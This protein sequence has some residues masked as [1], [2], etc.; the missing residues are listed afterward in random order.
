MVAKHCI[1]W[2]IC[3]YV[4]WYSGMIT[5]KF[6][7]FLVRSGF[8][9]LSFGWVSFWPDR[10]K[11]QVYGLF[12]EDI[13]DRSLIPDFGWSNAVVIEHKTEIL[14]R[15]CFDNSESLPSVTC[16]SNSKL[17]RIVESA[18]GWMSIHFLSGHLL[19]AGW[20]RSSLVRWLITFIFCEVV[21]HVH[22]L[23]RRSYWSLVC[24]RTGWFCLTKTDRMISS[25]GKSLNDGLDQMAMGRRTKA[26]G[27]GNWFLGGIVNSCHIRVKSKR[28][29][30][31]QSVHWIIYRQSWRH[32]IHTWS[33]SIK[34]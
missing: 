12:I 6:D 29:H 20:S 23:W 13:A 5:S 16:E 3:I 31:A 34:V 2:R 10:G 7:S 9:Y 24:M 14:W 11:F 30:V 15:F 8:V 32:M 19:W 4:E 17:H 26:N 27:K 22:L 28:P 1:E 21:D 33:D 25:N 18:F